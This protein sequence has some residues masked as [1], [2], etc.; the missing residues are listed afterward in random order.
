[1]ER[2]RRTFTLCPVPKRV[3]MTF[4]YCFSPVPSTKS[5]R[6]G[7]T[8][9]RRPIVSRKELPLIMKDS[10]ALV[11]FLC[12]STFSYCQTTDRQMEELAKEVCHSTWA[13]DS[14]Q[15]MRMHSAL[16]SIRPGI[17]AG[18]K[19]TYITINPTGKVTAWTRVQPD[20]SVTCFPT[21]YIDFE[22]DG[23]LEF[24][25]AHETGHAVDEFCYGHD[26]STEQEMCEL[27][28]DD[29]A[30]GILQKAG[31]NPV[32][33]VSLFNKKHQPRRIKNFENWK[34][35]HHG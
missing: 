13:K 28:A 14:P 9:Q 15:R 18:H 22:S 16:E 25:L 23:E 30:F 32:G 7:R 19:I 20:H 17:P 1:M 21:D 2:E 35:S 34:K 24:T 10:T 31:I 33:A 4:C 8:R 3:Y 29:I 11:V 5:L 12:L 6:V 26:H 27:R